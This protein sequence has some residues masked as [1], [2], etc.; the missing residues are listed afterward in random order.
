[1]SGLLK[2]LTPG[3]AEQTGGTG[4]RPGGRYLRKGQAPLARRPASE[5][6]SNVNQ[7]FCSANPRHRGDR[8]N[9]STQTFGTDGQGYPS[10]TALSRNAPTEVLLAVLGAH[11][12]LTP[13][14]NASSSAC[15]CKG[16]TSSLTLTHCLQARDVW[17]LWA[18]WHSGSA[19]QP[20]CRR[21]WSPRMTR[22][23]ERLATGAKKLT[24]TWKPEL[25]ADDR[26][27]SGNAIPRRWFMCG[28]SSTLGRQ[29]SS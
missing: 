2:R 3:N 1:M 16:T 5:G 24:S 4:C 11:Y 23:M 21:P 12:S 22:A 17:S 14:G 13:S 18:V 7:H 28:C 10:H 8:W 27:Y 6:A 25:G 19:H 26:D 29:F 20:G 15:A 9:A